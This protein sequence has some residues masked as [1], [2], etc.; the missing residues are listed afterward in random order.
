VFRYFYNIYSSFH[1]IISTY[2]IWISGNNIYIFAS[3]TLSIVFDVNW[4]VSNLNPISFLNSIIKYLIYY[5]CITKNSNHNQFIH[6][7]LFRMWIIHFPDNN[8]R[9]IIYHQRKIIMKPMM[10]FI[11][12]IPSLWCICEG[13]ILYL[14]N[15]GFLT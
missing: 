12:T 8:Y 14:H 9:K 6:I 13:I 4:F 11:F 7:F 10:A 5:K 15:L 1:L 2:C 3:S